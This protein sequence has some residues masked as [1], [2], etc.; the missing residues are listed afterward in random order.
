VTASLGPLPGFP[1]WTGVTATV[2]GPHRG[3]DGE[4]VA[5]MSIRMTRRGR[6]WAR[7]HALREGD[8]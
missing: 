2:T 6:L 3:R 7:Y 8:R 5:V 4:L 1:R